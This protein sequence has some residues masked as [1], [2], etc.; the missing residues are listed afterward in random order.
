MLGR[1]LRKIKV[2]VHGPCPP[3][4]WLNT[5]DLSTI[6]SVS[7]AVSVAFKMARSFPADRRIEALR[8]ATFAVPNEIAR[9]N[10]AA[11]EY[12]IK[13][14]GP[15]R[16]LDLERADF[17][18]NITGSKLSF[19]IKEDTRIFLYYPSPQTAKATAVFVAINAEP[20]VRE[21][22]ESEGPEGLEATPAAWQ[23]LIKHTVA[24]WQ[25]HWALWTA[26]DP[27]MLKNYFE[28]GSGNVPVIFSFQD[29]TCGAYFDMAA[30]TITEHMLGV[31]IGLVNNHDAPVVEAANNR[32]H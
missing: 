17:V 19:D 22:S 30:G 23:V 2:A 31:L 15:A 6:K 11:P 10:K 1:W 16:E 14:I 29:K 28:P 4:G 5:A 27:D 24:L 26:E 9:L 32:R 20:K 12:S 18:G 13:D 25:N 7:A 3:I 21:L 8:Q